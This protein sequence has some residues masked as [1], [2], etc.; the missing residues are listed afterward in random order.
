MTTSAKNLQKKGASVISGVLATLKV[1]FSQNDITYDSS[2]ESYNVKVSV[3][4]ISGKDTDRVLQEKFGV[5]PDSDW[6]ILDAT[7]VLALPMEVVRRA[8][9]KEEQDKLTERD[10]GEKAVSKKP[11]KAH[12]QLAQE[13]PRRGMDCCTKITIV[14]ISLLVIMC[15]I[16]SSIVYSDY[17]KTV[18]SKSA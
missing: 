1:N 11:K 16:L 7:V 10:F 8:V 2:S 5:H 15:S 9:E 6:T 13:S 17:S 14:F 3:S 4:Q 18:Q 12:T